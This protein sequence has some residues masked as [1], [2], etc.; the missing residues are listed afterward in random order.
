MLMNRVYL[1]QFTDEVG[2]NGVLCVCVYVCV[3]ATWKKKLSHTPV[4]KFAVFI[5]HTWYYIKSILIAIL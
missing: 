1:A 2:I 5:A 3:L 4:L